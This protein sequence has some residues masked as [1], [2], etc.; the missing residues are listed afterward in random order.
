[1]PQYA[2]CRREGEKVTIATSELI[3]GDIVE[4]KFGDRI[5][6]DIGG[7]HREEVV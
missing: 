4:I 6:A 2:L 1:M 7:D 3:L 5:P